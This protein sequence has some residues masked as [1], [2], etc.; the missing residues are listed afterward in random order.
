[1][2]A[3]VKDT[4][5]QQAE[6]ALAAKLG[7]GAGAVSISTGD[8]PDPDGRWR[9]RI[10]D[11]ASN[12]T[13]LMIE[14]NVPGADLDPTGAKD[15]IREAL[16]AIE[17]LSQIAQIK[18]D[19]VL[20]GEVLGQLKAATAD[21]DFNAKLLE[22]PG[23]NK[24]IAAR[25]WGVDDYAVSYVNNSAYGIELHLKIPT[26]KDT[27]PLPLARQ[28]TEEQKKRLESGEIK[29]I[30]EERVIK[31]ARANLAKEGK[32][33]EEIDA[34]VGKIKAD[35]AN[36]VISINEEY[37]RNV[38]ITLRSP[39]QAEAYK[40]AAGGFNEPD[41]ANE[42]RAENPLQNT[43]TSQLGKDE[44][45]Q[46]HKALARTLLFTK[47]E[48]GRAAK[49]IETF[50]L[51][52]GRHDIKVAI[53]KELSRIG[54]EKPEKAA[55]FKEILESPLFKEHGRW[56]SGSVDT[57]LPTAS[58]TKPADK[59]DTIQVTMMV[60][61][62]AK[63]FKGKNPV[64]DTIAAL[65][66]LDTQPQQQPAAEAAQP[67]ATMQQ[68]EST[69]VGAITPAMQE[70]AMAAAIDEVLGKFQPAGAGRG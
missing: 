41:N 31:Y 28:V 59:P 36:L 65:A 15:K 39:K 52:A 51:I 42:L 12:Q 5:I 16:S 1:M 69:A 30:L 27:G 47:D 23:F 21:T 3:L 20:A 43:L 44:Q 14:V 25:G 70:R 34:A 32:S 4:L 61:M 38:S 13:N 6:I 57:A 53:A 17:P 37:G 7:V 8:N 63:R 11:V 49:P 45:P 66:A 58:I 35:M 24:D 48:K 2:V 10:D 68:V 62:D 46:M 55:L 19:A 67:A 18:S 26:D 40:K 64:K 33:A 29:A 54:R 56:A 9:G 50:P 22:W 60:D